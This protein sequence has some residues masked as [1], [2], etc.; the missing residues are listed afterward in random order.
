MASITIRDLSDEVR[1]QLRLRAA[2]HGHSIED[3][4]RMILC[5]AVAGDVGP[6][7]LASAI[8]TRFATLGGVEL[9]ILPRDAMREPPRFE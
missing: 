4:A 9:E 2:G 1:T 7:T 3:V 8:R 6:V 5:Q